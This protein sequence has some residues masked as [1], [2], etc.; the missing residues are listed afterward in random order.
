M[1]GTNTSGIHAGTS[2]S[3]PSRLDC[4]SAVWAGLR[5]SGLGRVR[6]RNSQC[7]AVLLSA[8]LTLG[9][10]GY[11]RWRNK[12]GACGGQEHSTTIG[13]RATCIPVYRSS[14]EPWIQHQPEQHRNATHR[15]A[16]QRTCTFLGLAWPFGR[17]TKANSLQFLRLT[18]NQTPHQTLF[19]HTPTGSNQ[20]QPNHE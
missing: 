4:I 16:P 17:N 3:Q 13:Q 6:W 12:V 11:A 7:N 14:R 1:K 2:G 5:N 20:T 8:R 9:W 15:N 18:I 19:H 10:V